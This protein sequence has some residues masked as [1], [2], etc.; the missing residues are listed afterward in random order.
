MK[1]QIPKWRREQGLHEYAMTKRI[2]ESVLEE[3]KKHGA[4]RVTEVHLTIG[5][6]TFLG[7]EAVRAAYKALAKDTML[8]DSKLYI[9]FVKGVIKCPNCGYKG[10]VHLSEEQEHEHH[11]HYEET[12]VIYCPKC[13]SP[14]KVV[15]GKECVVKTVKM[16]VEDKAN[17]TAEV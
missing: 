11:E 6:F 15:S 8:E 17:G 1:V 7:E 10:G 4:H 14:A 3:A 13:E 9:E 5:E 16:K 12:P 2:V